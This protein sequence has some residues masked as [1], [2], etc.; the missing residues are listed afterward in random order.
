MGSKRVGHNWATKHTEIA[1]SSCGPPQDRLQWGN[2]VPPHPSAESWIKDLLRMALSTRAR[3]SFPQPISPIRKLALAS[4]SHLSEGRQKKQELQSND[5]Q[6]ENHNQGKL[7]KMITW[8]TALCNSVK[9]WVT[10]CWVTQDRWDMVESSDKT[11][12]IGREWQTTSEF[13]PWEPHEQYEKAKR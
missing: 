9:L 3:S 12:S 13:L 1:C 10:L 11:W 5:L 8:I 2:T 6:S 7:I 4:Y